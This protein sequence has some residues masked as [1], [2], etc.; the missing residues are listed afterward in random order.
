MIAALTGEDPMSGKPLD[1]KSL[2]AKDF[3]KIFSDRMLDALT[4][5]DVFKSLE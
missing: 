1:T 2:D 5:Q 3:S 4:G